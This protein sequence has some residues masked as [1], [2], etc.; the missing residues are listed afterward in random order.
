MVNPNKI[1]AH[2][3]AL[4]FG[5]PPARSLLW[6]AIRGALMAPPGSPLSH[7]RAA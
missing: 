5:E 6:V 1:P 2:I 4:A 7:F 3:R